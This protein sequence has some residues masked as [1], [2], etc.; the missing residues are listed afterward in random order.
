ML[1]DLS[2]PS[3]RPIGKNI[4]SCRR[5]RTGLQRTVNKMPFDGARMIFDGFE[6]IVEA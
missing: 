6:V 4:A 1:M 5:R 3:P 2:V